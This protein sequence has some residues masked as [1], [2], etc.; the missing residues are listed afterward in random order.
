MKRP[1][2]VVI[3]SVTIEIVVLAA[4]GRTCLNFGKLC[5]DWPEVEVVNEQSMSPSSYCAGVSILG[6]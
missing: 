3:I 4:T 2:L 6:T 1:Q 5:Q